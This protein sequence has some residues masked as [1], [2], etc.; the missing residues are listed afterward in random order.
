[1][2]GV[3]DRPITLL[4]GV[5]LIYIVP[6]PYAIY[7]YARIQ[8]KNKSFSSPSQLYNKKICIILC[9]RPIIS[10]QMSHHTCHAH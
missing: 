1:M 3:S 4:S 9:D 2:Y 5:V 7:C 6:P 10:L 8:F